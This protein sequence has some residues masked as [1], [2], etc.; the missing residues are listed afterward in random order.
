MADIVWGLIFIFTARVL[1]M[2]MA[3]T[4]TLFVVKGR[5][6]AAAGIGFAESIIYVLALQKV[7]Q[8]LDNPLNLIVYGL[9]FSVGNIVGIVIEEKMAM[10]YLTVQVITL[11]E[12]LELTIRLRKEGFGVTVIAGE[13]REGIRYIIQIVLSRKSLPKLRKIIDNWDPAAFV[14]VFDA[15][16]IKG[17]IPMFK[18]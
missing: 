1:D 15:R 13:G 12:P 3:T 7:F 6:L 2:S 16:T 18:R 8:T 9:G 17:G 4:R 14:T 5:K 11:V 10:G